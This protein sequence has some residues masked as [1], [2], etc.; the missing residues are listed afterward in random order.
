MDKD[1]MDQEEIDKLFEEF[2]KEEPQVEGGGPEASVAPRGSEILSQEEIDALLRGLEEGQI[3]LEEAEVPV[4]EVPGLRP[5]DFRQWE[6]LE[7]ERMERLG[8][9]LER[10]SKASGSA[11]SEYL[12][13]PVDVDLAE[14]KAMYFEEF[15]KKVPVPTGLIILKVRP[16]EDYALLVLDARTVFYAIDVLFGGGRPGRVKVEGREFTSIEMRVIKNLSG[17][18]LESLEEA[19]GLM[20]EVKFI[21]EKVELSPEFAV[22]FFR[23]EAVLSASFEV[24]FGGALGSMTLCLPSGLLKALRD[25]AMGRGEVTVEVEDPKWKEALREALS[26]VW[27][28]VQ[29]EFMRKKLTLREL[30]GLKE[31]DLVFFGPKA[32]EEVLG[33][34]QGVPLF[35]GRPGLSKGYRAVKITEILS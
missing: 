33:K 11:L 12:H 6:L 32:E 1:I 2:A 25:R 34:V 21:P 35:K 16:E 14:K 24:D 15:I 28:M 3:P 20:C 9:V 13:R 29:V 7:L 30:L 17:I 8:L 5:F 31:G 10:F 18:L 4:E 27:V 23:K 22:L 19:F 26:E